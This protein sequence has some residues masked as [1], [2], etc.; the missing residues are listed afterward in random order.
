MLWPIL[1]S[2]HFTPSCKNSHRYPSWK[3]ITSTHT[4]CTRITNP[5]FPLA[6]PPHMELFTPTPTNAFE[7]LHP[8]FKLALA[9]ATLAPPTH[10]VSSAK[11]HPHTLSPQRMLFNFLCLTRSLFHVCNT[12]PTE[13]FILF[14]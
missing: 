14:L 8:T 7:S 10:F 9:P 12:N 3:H 13:D 5:L 11:P 6:P 2:S 1:N 4:I